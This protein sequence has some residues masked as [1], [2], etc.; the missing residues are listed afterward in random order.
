LA[1]RDGRD[2]VQFVR[3]GA[4]SGNRQTTIASRYRIILTRLLSRAG[5]DF[6]E[7]SVKPVI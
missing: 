5:P 4:Q 2:E 3:V 7:I 6:P 1:A